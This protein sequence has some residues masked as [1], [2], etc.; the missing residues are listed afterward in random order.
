LAKIK[1]ERSHGGKKF[2]GGDKQ[3]ENNC[4]KKKVDGDQKW[5][6]SEKN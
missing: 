4:E 2:S 6:G 1:A 5:N 3:G